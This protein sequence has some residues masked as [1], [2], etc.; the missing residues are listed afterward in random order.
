[1]HICRAVANAGELRELTRTAQR[2]RLIGRPRLEETRL[3]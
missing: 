2:S 3:G 1:V